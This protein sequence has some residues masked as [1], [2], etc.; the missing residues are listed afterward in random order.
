LFALLQIAKE[1]GLEKVYVHGFL[2]GRDVGPQ[3]ALP[4]IEQ[5]EERMYQLGIGKFATISGRYYAMDRDKRWERVQLAYDAICHGKGPKFNQASAAV[6]NSY[7]EDVYD[8]FVLPSVIMDENEEPVGSVEDND[9]IIF[10]N[11]RPDRAIQLS[12]SFANADFAEFDRGEAPKNVYFVQMTE[13]SDTVSGDIA[14]A[15]VDLTNTVGEVIANNDMKQLRIAETEKYPHVTYFLSGGREAEFPGE[16]CIL[17]NSP[18]VATY[19]LK[20]EM[21]AYEVTD[22]LLTEIDAGE[23]NAIMLNFA[24]PDMVGHSGMLEPTIKSIEVVDEC[25][26]KIVDKIIELDGTAIITADHGNADEV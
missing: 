16:K 8:E 14:F 22:A 11:F 20:P 25:L 17:I 26:G 15:T 5:A 7:E 4:Y 1:H 21:S 23:V 3:T 24:N 10:F 6:E 12:Q 13:Y 18:K 19:D 9:A 2:D